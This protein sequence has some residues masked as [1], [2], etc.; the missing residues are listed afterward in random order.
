M[1][2]EQW[3]R[4]W[5]IY[6]TAADLDDEERR[7]FLASLTTDPEVLSEVI[8]MLEEARAANLGRT[9]REP[10]NRSGTRFG[11]YEVGEMLSSGG[12]G[13]VYS[14]GDPELDRKVAI[15]F[16]SPEMAASRPAVERLI[17]EAK[18]A[19]ALN[20]PHII[21]VYE[22]I[23]AKNDV[24][25]AMELVEGRALRKF[26]GKPVDIVQVI[27]WGRQIAQA[28]AAAHQRNNIHRDVKPENLMVRDDG[29]LKVLD[30]G[31]AGQSGGEDQWASTTR[32]VALA[33]CGKTL[34]NKL[35]K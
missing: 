30:F 14:A 34:R 5:D 32:F 2:D 22:V 26:C 1:N 12:M 25:I 17:R 15:K 16:L 21:T 20:H 33:G 13:E 24:A 8:S 23:R 9:L 3:R 27:H 29:I 35:R 19:S 10:P 6:A 4:T 31:L 11:R 7:A 18:A 28:L